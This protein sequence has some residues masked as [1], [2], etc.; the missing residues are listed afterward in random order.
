MRASSRYRRSQQ[1]M[2][3]PGG[4]VHSWCE[5]RR[6]RGACQPR[7]GSYDCAL[8]R[9]RNRAPGMERRTTKASATDLGTVRR[10]SGRATP[11]SRSASRCPTSFDPACCWAWKRVQCMPAKDLRMSVGKATRSLSVRLSRSNYLTRRLCLAPG[12]S[13]HS[14]A[15]TVA[16][17]ISISPPSNGTKPS[18]DSSAVS[19]PAINRE[20]R[21]PHCFIY[22]S[23]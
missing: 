17:G 1:D 23:A 7:R 6:D 16:Q 10:V 3:R 21:P 5:M 18:C 11:A 15:K 9:R 13:R 4:T 20:V 14:G 12:T 22:H 8:T 19:D 2:R